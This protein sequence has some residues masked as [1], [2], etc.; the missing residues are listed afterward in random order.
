MLIK[1]G[2]DEDAIVLMDA[3]QSQLDEQKILDM[4]KVLHSHLLFVRGKEKL[5]QI[6]ENYIVKHDPN[7]TQDRMT[8]RH[9]YLPD[10]FQE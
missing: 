3:A 10:D 2:E 6:I 1:I 5:L 9:Y 7:E 8:N 4:Y